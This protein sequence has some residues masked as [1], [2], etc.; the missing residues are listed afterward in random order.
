VGLIA[1]DVLNKAH[2]LNFRYKLIKHHF[3]LEYLNKNNFHLHEP[4]KLS[5]SLSFIRPI[6]ASWYQTEQFLYIRVLIISQVSHQ[7]RYQLP[8]FDFLSK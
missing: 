5:K 7:G 1:Y 4:H 3:P 8:L 6:Q 2:P